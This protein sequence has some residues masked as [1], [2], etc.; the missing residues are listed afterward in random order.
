MPDTQFPNCVEFVAKIGPTAVAISVAYVAWKQWETARA[1]LRFDLFQSRLKVYNAIKNLNVI[2]ALHGAILPKDFDNLVGELDGAE[3][4]FR[5]DLRRHIEAIQ[6]MA[7]RAMM[8]RQSYN[9]S[10]DHPLREQLIKEEDEVIH[11]LREQRSQIEE[12]FRPELDLT[13]H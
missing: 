6:E 3:F 10:L 11:Y 2:A 9:K 1:K 5:D 7:W 4:L 8:A 13:R 12:L